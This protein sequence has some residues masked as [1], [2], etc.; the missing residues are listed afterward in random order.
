MSLFEVIAVII[1]VIAVVLT[2]K[3]HLLCWPFNFLSYVLYAILFF[4]FKLYGESILQFFFMALAIY[5]YLQWKKGLDEQHELVVSHIKIS[6]GIY[7]LILTSG[8]GLMFGALL[9]WF[10]DAAVPWLDSQLAAFSLLAT[11]WTSK[12]YISTWSLW[13]IVDIIYVGMFVFKS[14]YLTAA[15]YA[16]FVVLAAMGWMQWRKAY[17]QQLSHKF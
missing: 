1:S 4:D 17:L 10:T 16:A 15:L 9:A 11:Y 7:Q 3:R 8:M 2:I 6:T 14:L 12:K 13:V 5:G